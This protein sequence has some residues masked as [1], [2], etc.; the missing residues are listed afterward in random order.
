MEKTE[1][2]RPHKA[3]YRPSWEKIPMLKNWIQS[4]PGKP[5]K[6]FCRF[7]QRLLYAHRYSV[8]KHTCTTKHQQNADKF[9][10]GAQPSHQTI[11]F[12]NRK[13]N[14]TNSNCLSPQRNCADEPPVVSTEIITLADEKDDA[15]LELNDEESKEFLT[16]ISTSVSDD[17]CHGNVIEEEVDE[18]DFIVEDAE[19]EKECAEYH[20]EET[21][22]VSAPS[23]PS[24]S[25]MP[26]HKSLTISTHILDTSRGRAATNVPVT[27]FKLENDIWKQISQNVTNQDGRAPGLV[28]N[29]DLTVGLYKLHFD[30]AEYFK[31]TT[32]R[33]LYPFVEI[34][35]NCDELGHYHIPLLLNPFGYST[36]R[37][38]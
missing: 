14:N 33:F 4:V 16:F 3:M 24:S 19:D 21:V 12:T 30:T 9:K 2:K 36:Y 26:S 18:V 7:C 10:E 32:T 27:L 20:F 34:V 28:P 22:E 25:D 5:D 8:L 35:F 31:Q 17:P 23:S 13:T 6:A 29:G 11:V 37:G 1:K 38:T 15:D